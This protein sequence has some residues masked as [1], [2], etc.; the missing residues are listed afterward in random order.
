MFSITLTICILTVI[1]SVS[2]FN[3]EKIK[4]DLL[5]WPAHINETRQYYRF[6]TYG[7]V[8]ADLMHLA[9]NMLSF[10]SFGEALEIRL[11]SHPSLFAS[12]GKLFFILL[13]VLGL[14]FSTLP[15][16][17]AYKNVYAYRALGASGAVCAVIFS[18][19]MLEPKQ[20]MRMFF[21][22]IDI[23]GYI[24]GV[25]FLAISIW[26]GKRGGDNIGHR[27]HITGAIIGII[28][29]I[30]CSKVFAGYDVIAAFKEAVIGN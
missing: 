15:D 14:I 10:Y 27:A 29:T 24:F 25:I 21:I 22:P 30:I 5:F 4:N 26:L 17:F 1:V 18:F 12:Q 13:Y 23:P 20:P 19:I 8:H 9:F 2:A 6:L 7:F 16:Y 28:F 3:S 11:F